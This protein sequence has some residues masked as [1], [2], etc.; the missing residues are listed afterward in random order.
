MEPPSASE[1]RADPAPALIGWDIGGAHLKAAAADAAGRIRTVVQE[2]CP[3]WQGQGELRAALERVWARLGPGPGC[4][5]AITMTGEL[6]DIF[7]DRT[8]GVLALVRMM[9]DHCPPDTVAVF[10]GSGEFLQAEAVQAKDAPAIASAN[11]LASGLWV[12]TR[13]PEA[14]LVD[15]G[16]TTTDLVPIWDRQ[17][18]PRGFTDGERMGFDELLYTGVVRTPVMAV[19]ERAPLEGTWVGVMAEQFATMAD[20]YRLT[21]ELPEQADQ[22]PAADGRGKTPTDSARRLARMFG[23]DGLSAALERWRRVAWY[24]RERQLMRLH[25]GVECQL[26]RGL[27]GPAA[28]L[29]GAGSGRFLVRELAA[30]LRRPYRDFDE[31]FPLPP[32]DGGFRPADC[33]PAAALAALALER[34]RR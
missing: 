32:E 5:H 15:I 16:S 28:P 2:P 17:P 30:R 10:T 24:V 8:T 27:L 29:V 11:W 33:A 14:L 13:L 26:S 22:L 19:V 3:L 7:P 21:G 34:G 12:A 25:A 9:I 23:R 31:L 1:R 20:V 6:A 18:R 4:R